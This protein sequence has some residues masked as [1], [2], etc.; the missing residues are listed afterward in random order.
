MLSASILAAA[1]EAT[2]DVG[3]PPRASLTVAL[4]VE[5]LLFAAFAVSYSLAHP[6]EGGRHPFFAQAWFGWCIVITISAVAVSAG[7]AWWATFE[8][9]WPTETNEVLRA[10]GLALGIVAQPIFA[11]VI[12]WQAR[13]S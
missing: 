4:T 9:D 3:L 11:A 5:G 10:G 7:A 6:T 12:N 8:A 2:D 1:S 13:S